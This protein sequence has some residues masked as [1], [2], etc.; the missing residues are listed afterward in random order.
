[1]GKDKRLRRF[2][3]NP[4]ESNVLS[5]PSALLEGQLEDPRRTNQ[6]PLLAELKTQLTTR[7]PRKGRE[8]KRRLD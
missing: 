1:M 8:R 6:F 7:L 2:P 3:T 4:K 5:E